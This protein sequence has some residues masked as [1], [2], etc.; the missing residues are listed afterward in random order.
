MATAII[1]SILITAGIGILLCLWLGISAIRAGLKIPFYRTR[2]QRIVTGWRLIGLAFLLAIFAWA[3]VRFG[4]PL[5][6]F[7]SW[8]KIG[9]LPE[10]R[11]LYK[12]LSII[13]SIIYFASL[14]GV[15]RQTALERGENL[16][17]RAELLPHKNKKIEELSHGMGQITQVI[18]TIIHEPDLIILDE[19]FAGLDPVNTQL[20]KDLI[21]ELRSNGKTIIMST[22]RMNDIEELSD[23]LLMINKGRTVLYGDLTEIKSKYRNNSVV[24][25]SPGELG[26]IEGVIEQRRHNRSMELVLDDKITPQ[27]ILEQLVKKGVAV[28]R[29]ELSTPS[30]NEIFIKVVGKENE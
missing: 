14:K 5:A 30:L 20:L 12:K 26:E 25:E 6:A 22:H 8:N 13:E 2:Q 21:R 1:Q 15:D 10:E 4:Q 28:N 17:K 16:L 27:M 3:S 11:G 23:R 29:F 7:S 19:P 18:I 9:Y 24:V